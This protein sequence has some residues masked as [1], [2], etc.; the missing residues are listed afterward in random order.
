[1]APS[2]EPPRVATSGENPVAAGHAPDTVGLQRVLAPPDAIGDAQ[3]RLRVLRL[4]LR[5]VA[6]PAVFLRPG[7]ELGLRAGARLPVRF[8]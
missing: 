6:P 8:F 2:S 3:L 4:A 1:M 5:L 7:E